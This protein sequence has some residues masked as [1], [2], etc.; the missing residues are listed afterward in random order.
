MQRP[1]L[2][3]TIIAD[4]LRKA[5]ALVGALPGNEPL[6]DR[7]SGKDFTTRLNRILA[8]TLKEL[9]YS[10]AEIE[11][12]EDERAGKRQQEPG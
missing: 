1:D 10:K 8:V 12:Y 7:L 5:R 3:G 11:A 4:A 9:G 6:V 2:V